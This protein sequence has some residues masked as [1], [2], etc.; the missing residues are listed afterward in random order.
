MVV[1]RQYRL[2]GPIALMPQLTEDATSSA[3]IRTTKPGE[4]DGR[5]AE[6]YSVAALPF[7]PCCGISL[8]YPHDGP[9]GHEAVLQP[10]YLLAFEGLAS[11]GVLAGPTEG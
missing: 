2:L 11:L 8:P 4:D 10:G 1:G 9:S 5:T 6:S 3:L 7:I